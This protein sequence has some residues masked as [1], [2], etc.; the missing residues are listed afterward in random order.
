MTLTQ[1]DSLS[2]TLHSLLTDRTVRERNKELARS[3]VADGYPELTCESLLA[4]GDRVTV[5]ATVANGESRWSL[6]AEIRFD[7]AGKVAEYH[8]FLVPA[9]V[10]RA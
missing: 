1:H 5:R 8:D 4:D 3:L 7:G 9:V 6:I 10:Q 2:G